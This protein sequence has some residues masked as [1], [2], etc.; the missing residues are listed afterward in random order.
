[1]LLNAFLSS[2]STVQILPL[3]KL[4]GSF[5]DFDN[6]QIVL[7]LQEMLYLVLGVRCDSGIEEGSEIR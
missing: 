4:L 2:F 5:N 6:Y 1:M 7:Q 3:Q